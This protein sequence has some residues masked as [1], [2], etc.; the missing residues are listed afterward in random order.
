MA[1]VFLTWQRAQD[2]CLVSVELDLTR[3]GSKPNLNKSK[4]IHCTWAGCSTYILVAKSYVPQSEAAEQV[5]P[6]PRFDFTAWTWKHEDRC[7]SSWG[8][9]ESKGPTSHTDLCSELSWEQ[10][11]QGSCAEGWQ[12]CPGKRQ[13]TCW[14][15]STYSRS[16]CKI[17]IHK[18]DHTLCQISIL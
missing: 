4:K 16:R 7:Q 5:L 1:E 10:L 12:P 14:S 9:G 6:R 18:A 2:F 8:E 17:L 11:G 3:A 13:V 15:F